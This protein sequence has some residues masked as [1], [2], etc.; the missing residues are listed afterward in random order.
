MEPLNDKELNHLL[1]QWRAP[2]APDTLRIP[3]SPRASVWRWL[4]SGRIHVPVPAVVLALTLVA[5]FLVFSFKAK[6]VALNGT[7]PIGN[8]VQSVLPSDAS[9]P[10]SVPVPPVPPHPVQPPAE[11]ESQR[12]SAALAG[13]R[14]VIQFEPRI[15]GVVK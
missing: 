4:W 7:A 6:N 15:V 8:A 5:A 1:R 11:P 13:F 2:N 12:E 10:Q 14:P 9:H 3:L